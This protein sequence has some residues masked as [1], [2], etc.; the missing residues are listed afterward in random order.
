MVNEHQQKKRKNAK[1]YRK[2][3]KELNVLITK[4]LQNFVK[5]KKRR[6]TEKEL[7]HFQQMQLSDEESKK[8]IFQLGR[9]RRKWRTPFS[10][11]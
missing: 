6:K 7:Q 1:S 3:N 10:Q 2:S 4:I 8:S 5:N 9:K 11:V